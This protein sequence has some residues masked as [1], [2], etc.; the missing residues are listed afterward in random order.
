MVDRAAGGLG[1]F[2]NF[3][4]G[5]NQGMQQRTAQKM[6]KAQSLMNLAQQMASNI[7]SS[8]T[9]EA[10]SMAAKHVQS[11]MDQA[12]KEMKPDKSTW[13]WFRG[14]FGGKGKDE[15]NDP[16]ETLGLS[17]LYSYTGGAGEMK[18][19][20][21]GAPTQEAKSRLE[22]PP[23]E[24]QSQDVNKDNVPYNREATP[25]A[26]GGTGLAAGV[27]LP[28]TG[29][30]APPSKI[31]SPI[32]KEQEKWAQAK[33][34]G[35][36]W[37]SPL[38]PG[39]VTEDRA[40]GEG[41]EHVRTKP[42][43]SEYRYNGQPISYGEYHDLLQEQAKQEIGAS[44]RLTENK[45][46]LGQEAAQERMKA[47]VKTEQNNKLADSYVKWGR[48]NDMYDP[49]TEQQIRYGVKVDNAQTWTQT[50][51]GA[52]GL[53]HQVLV[54]RSTNQPIE[55]TDHAL[56]PSAMEQKVL[57]IM[58]TE[59]NADGSP[60]TYAQA[61]QQYWQTE[62][63]DADAKR[64]LEKAQL[65]NTNLLGQIREKT[66]KGG[67]NKETIRSAAASLKTAAEKAATNELTGLD[68]DKFLLAWQDLL[69][70]ALGIS[71]DKVVEAYG[72]DPLLLDESEDMEAE[73]YLGG[74]EPD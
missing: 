41:L 4:E 38:A 59:K 43:N 56:E 25:K 28:T 53:R 58:N 71:W 45:L 39:V 62:A 69:T 32:E 67:L 26:L 19:V 50:Y 63:Q 15:L 11:L 70:K 22:V 14:I 13:D 34:W 35:E 40:T 55:V 68:Q 23:T 6:Q 24:Q 47:D 44:T 61:Q 51:R 64:I 2:G 33:R 16:V 30:T 3:I 74:Y 46:K 5:W 57:T 37:G 42:G 36:Q 72:G 49:A 8:M 54:N 27:E 18:P 29:R 10:R 17:N 65:N 7:D 73:S 66:L 20:E 1:L 60:M 52:D 21:G 31:F 48:Q 12:Q 9:S